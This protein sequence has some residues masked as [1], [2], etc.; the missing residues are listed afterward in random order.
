M[1]N[2]VHVFELY[3]IPVSFNILLKGLV[4]LNVLMRLVRKQH[5]RGFYDYVPSFGKPEQG[6]RILK[7]LAVAPVAAET[8]VGLEESEI[9]HLTCHLTSVKLAPPPVFNLN[10][11]SN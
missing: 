5:L 11:K 10:K 9:L 7:I 3:L 4:C 2:I 1:L 8:I 6:L